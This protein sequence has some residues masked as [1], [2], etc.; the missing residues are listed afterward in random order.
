M[1]FSLV[2]GDAKTNAL[3]AHEMVTVSGRGQL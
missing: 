3:K 1:R 2:V